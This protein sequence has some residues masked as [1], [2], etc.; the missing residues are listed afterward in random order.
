[1][2]VS[3]MAELLR[4]VLLDVVWNPLT[5]VGG[6]VVLLSFIACGL[7]SLVDRNGH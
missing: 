2:S 6:I 4:N 3:E 5:V 7:A 1:M